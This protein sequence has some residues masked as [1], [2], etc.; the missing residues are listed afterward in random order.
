MINV[1]W[2]TSLIKQIFLCKVP[3]VLFFAS[4]FDIL[5]LSCSHSLSTC[6]LCSQ[7]HGHTMEIHFFAA[8]FYGLFCLNWLDVLVC[9]LWRSVIAQLSHID[10]RDVWF[11][12]WRKSITVVSHSIAEKQSQT[13]S[14]LLNNTGETNSVKARTEANNIRLIRHFPVSGE[15]QY[16]ELCFWSIQEMSMVK[17]IKVKLT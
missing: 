4:C 2:S 15:T 16:K 9:S 13:R 17:N 14:N 8:P 6:I 10:Q 12:W 7:T 3:Q 1:F 5:L 11:W